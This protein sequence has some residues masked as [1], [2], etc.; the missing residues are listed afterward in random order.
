MV[1]SIRRL[2]CETHVERDEVVLDEVGVLY[3]LDQGTL[4]S[5]L[6]RLAVPNA[7]D[8]VLKVDAVDTSLVRGPDGLP[9]VLSKG[10]SSFSLMTLE[11]E[12]TKV[13]EVGRLEGVSLG[14]DSVYF[15]HYV[16]EARRYR[17]EWV[18]SVGTRTMLWEDTSS[19]VLCEG[20][21]R[22][23]VFLLSTAAELTIVDRT[24]VESAP[25]PSPGAIIIGSTV[26]EDSLFVLSHRD[27]TLSL[28]RFG[29]AESLWRREALPT[30]PGACS[31]RQSIFDNCPLEST[32]LSWA[33]LELGASLLTIADQPVA[34]VAT[35]SGSGRCGWSRMYEIPPRSVL[36]EWDRSG[37]S[38]IIDGRLITSVTGRRD[39]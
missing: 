11:G 35:S 32:T 4:G 22:T 8:A 23:P 6:Y 15:V 21:S 7:R 29:D 26:A 34:F 20:P 27:H 5:T 10:D 19:G 14:P 31:S 13:D 36:C 25:N 28:S 30:Y 17:F 9:L 24:G 12:E 18:S 39:P 16:S 37:A 38:E 2:S 3:V 1:G 33:D